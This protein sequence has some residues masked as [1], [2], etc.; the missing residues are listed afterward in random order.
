MG[1]PRFVY[2]SS[3]YCNGLISTPSAQ[4]HSLIP[5]PYLCVVCTLRLVHSQPTFWVDSKYEG[6]SN[7]TE[8]ICSNTG[9]AGSIHLLHTADLQDGL[10]EG[11][12]SL[13]YQLLVDGYTGAGGVVDGSL[14]R[15]SKPGD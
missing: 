11:E 15:I 7:I 2:R 10:G 12:P 13:S 9:V 6:S 14:V 1:W 3:T 4:H 5:R 8:T